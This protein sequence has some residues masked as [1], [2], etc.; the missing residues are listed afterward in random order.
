[1]YTFVWQESIISVW[2]MNGVIQ[3]TFSNKIKIIKYWRETEAGRQTAGS[4]FLET[5]NFF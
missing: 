2:E 3:D 4:Y 1:V 5:S